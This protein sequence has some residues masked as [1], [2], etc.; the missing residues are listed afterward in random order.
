MR[1]LIQQS[2]EIFNVYGKQPEAAKSIFQGFHSILEN[3]EMADITRAFQHWM[4]EK[5]TMPTPSDI[6]SRA[7]EIRKDRTAQKN[8]PA[9][10]PVP[11]EPVKMVPWAYKRWENFT[12]SD[13]IGL[14]EHLASMDSD[15][16]ATYVNYLVNWCGSPKP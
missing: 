16:R 12:E 11:K 10:Q 15:K 5:S 6:L 3:H 8:Y 14:D 1:Y 13:R 9:A 7:D 2:F 4:Q